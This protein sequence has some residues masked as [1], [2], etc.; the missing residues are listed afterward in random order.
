MLRRATAQLDFGIEVVGE[1]ALA[2]L[3]RHHLVGAENVEILRDQRMLGDR[4]ADGQCH[5]D[6]VVDEAVALQLHLP[7]RHVQAGDQ[8]LV[9]AGRGVGEHRLV[10]LRLHGVELDV[11][12]QQHR[13]L[14]QGRHRLVRGVASDRR[15]A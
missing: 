3:L 4:L 12:H 1:A 11:L 8:L 14:A 13:A 10:E 9:G 2:I 6:R 15:A 5:L 7:A